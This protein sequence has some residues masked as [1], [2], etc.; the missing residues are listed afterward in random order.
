MVIGMYY[1]DYGTR[2]IKLHPIP[3]SYFPRIEYAL[4][5]KLTDVQKLKLNY[6]EAQVFSGRKQG[7]TL[8]HCILV[9]LSIGSPIK[10][11]RA[12]DYG[13]GT[14]EYKRNFF[15]NRYAEVVERLESVGFSTRQVG[16]VGGWKIYNDTYVIK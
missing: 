1:R 3:K 6:P 2:P 16:N 7:Q 14:I 5:I 11:E 4:G 10:A 15:I 8:T 9:A 12:S 13:N